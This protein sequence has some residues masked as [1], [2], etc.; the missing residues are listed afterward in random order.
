LLEPLVDGELDPKR[1][2]AVR[3]HLGACASCRAEHEQAASL[4][5]RLR[6]LRAPD[7]PPSLAA[8]VMRSVAPRGSRLAWALLAAQVLVA[9]GIGSYVSGLSGL[10]LL[11]GGVAGDLA[12]LAG[13]TSGA[14]APPP[15]ASADVFLLLAFIGL[16][17]LA[18]WHLALL[19]RPT[20]GR[21]A[22]TR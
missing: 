19:A 11:A 3:A 7:P 2:L 4:P 12:S 14:A 17:G 10:A 20:S 21:L 1:E 9:T 22:R 15:P 8:D 5:T 16:M 6:A 13:W 18:A